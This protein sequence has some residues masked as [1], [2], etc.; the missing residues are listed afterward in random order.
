MKTGNHAIR[1]SQATTGAASRIG[2]APRGRPGAAMLGACLFCLLVLGGSFNVEAP[3]ARVYDG[4]SIMHASMQENLCVLTFDDG[5]SRNTPHI[6]DVLRDH[7]IRASFFMLGENIQRHPEHVR[8]ILAEGHE[9]GNHSFSHPNLRRVGRDRKFSELKRTH[10]LLKE[11][12]ANP[13]YM[14]PP[15][16]S[17]DA[18]VVRINDDLGLSMIL[19][20]VDS[21]DWK[22]RPANYAA[23]RNGDGLPFAAGGMRGIFLFH[24]PLKTT[25]ADLEKIIRELRAGGCQRFVTVEEYLENILDTR[26]PVR[27]A[28]RPDLVENVKPAEQ[29]GSGTPAGAEAASV[30][31]AVSPDAGIQS[32]PSG[33]TPLPMARSSRPWADLPA[34]LPP[35][36]NAPASPQASTRDGGMINLLDVHERLVHSDEGSAASPGAAETH[37]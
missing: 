14:R 18:E 9:V 35:A 4:V 12:G 34:A 30:A 27:M 7:G 6:L 2:A 13:R 1:F 32:W 10:D 24:D 3:H 22:R 17:Y 25:A 26:P 37:G 23:L 33:S 36:G 16:G 15:Y 21:R 29:A 31:E 20:S 28:K 8:R 11:M 5:P 19:W